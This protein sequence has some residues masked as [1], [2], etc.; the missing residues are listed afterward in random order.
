VTQQDPQVA[1]GAIAEDKCWLG[2]LQDEL[3]GQGSDVRPLGAMAVASVCA[4]VP[5]AAVTADHFRESLWYGTFFL[6]AA[7][8]QLGLAGCL[9]TRPA[10]AVV[11][12]GVAGSVLV[13]ALWLVT[14]AIGIPVGPDRGTAEPLG[15]LDGISTVAGICVAVL[16]V[17]AL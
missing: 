17:L 1:A 8:S 5:H 2:Q 13:L 9:L 16:G 14:R 10:R 11:R 6:V 3:R 7:A 4:A 15:L 12:A